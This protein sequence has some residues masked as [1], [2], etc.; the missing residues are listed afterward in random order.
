MKT[1]RY[2]SNFDAQR[3]TVVRPV[4]DG[5]HA[6]QTVPSGGKEKGPGSCSGSPPSAVAPRLVPA[7]AVGVPE[8]GTAPAK[9]SF[10]GAAAAKSWS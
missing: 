5:V 9:L 10:A 2:V 6:Y 4:T 1:S 8:S 7:A 3:S